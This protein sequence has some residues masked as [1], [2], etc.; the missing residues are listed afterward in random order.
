MGIN[1]SVITEHDLYGPTGP[2]VQRPRLF[3]VEFCLVGL[4]WPAIQ[5]VYKV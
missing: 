1:C 4:I 5:N 2:H 3:S